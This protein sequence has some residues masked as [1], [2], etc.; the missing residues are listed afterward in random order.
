MV[1][2]EMLDS[3]WFV[4]FVLLVFVIVMLIVVVVFLVML[5]IFNCCMGQIECKGIEVNSLLISCDQKIVY[6][7]NFEFKLIDVVIEMLFVLVEV[8]MDD[9]VMLGVQIE[10]VIFG[11]NEMDCEEVVGVMCIKCLCDFLGNQMIS[12]FL[13]KNIVK[14]GYMLVI[15]KDVI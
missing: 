2:F 10:V 12:E 1:F 11:C 14:K 5:V 7:N 15:E 6:L 8:C 4:I 3:Y 13:V 9:E